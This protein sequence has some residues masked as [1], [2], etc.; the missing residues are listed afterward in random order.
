VSSLV[1]AL[2]AAAAVYAAG[3]SRTAERRLS[4][5]LPRPRGSPPSPR[6]P[7]QPSPSVVVAPEADRHRPASHLVAVVGVLAAGV[8]VLGGSG[9]LVVGGV[10]ALV[11]WSALGRVEPSSVRRLRDRLA[12]ELPGVADLVAACLECGATPFAAVEAAAS[13]LGAPWDARLLPPLD[14]IRL[15]ADPR[16][17][18]ADLAAEPATAPLAAVLVRAVDDG[19][20]LVPLLRALATDRR[21]ERRSE[22]RQRAQRVGVLALGP[23]GACFLPA[24]VLLGV[25]PTVVSVGRSVLGGL[26]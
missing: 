22:A 23:L 9:G 8:L 25:V 7:T 26:G 21:R 4:A 20:A 16:R 10:A 15:G 19:V 14:A 17:A 13:A 18:W 12:A 24:F 5:I 1:S 11:A 3:A 2:L 6:R